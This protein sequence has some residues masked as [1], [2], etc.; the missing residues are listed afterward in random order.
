[1][2]ESASDIEKST[3]EKI[4]ATARELF[5][6]YGF[7]GT[8]TRDIAEQSGI[9][10]ALLNYYFR[11]KA[12]LFHIIMEETLEQ[13]LEVLTTMLRDETTTFEEK[14]ERVTAGYIDLLK[15]NPDMPT[16]VLGELRN[17]QGHLLSTINPRE[18]LMNSNFLLQY[19]QKVSDGTIAPIPPL[20]FL[21]NLVSMIVFPFVGSPLLRSMGDLSHAEFNELM[22]Q[23]KT[24]IPQW[25]NATL[26]PE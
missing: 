5:N 11:S 25:I 26:K 15:A 10:L 1:M 6:K 22:D 16:F 13:F 8:K 2:S 23:R 24:M 12:K 7:S 17:N 20:Q 4:K 21:M 19:Q 18:R 14:I 9:N 3:E